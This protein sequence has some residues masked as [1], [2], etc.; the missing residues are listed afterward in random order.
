MGLS[1]NTRQAYSEIDEFLSLLTEEQ[2]NKIP[3]K[4]R[5]F[6]KEEK[7]KEYTK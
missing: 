4:L 6:F 1:I 3:L 2:I 7:D 5:K